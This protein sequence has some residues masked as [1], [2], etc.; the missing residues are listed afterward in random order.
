MASTAI[1]AERLAEDRLFIGGEWIDAASGR[2]FD[3]RFPA[4]GE[5]IAQVA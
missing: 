3:V 1:A 2:T 4:T 5:V